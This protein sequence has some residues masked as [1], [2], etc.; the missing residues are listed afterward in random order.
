MRVVK[1]ELFCMLKIV[2]GLCREW[3]RMCPW[4]AFTMVWRQAVESLLMAEVRVGVN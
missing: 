2:K 3:G 4:H 1:W